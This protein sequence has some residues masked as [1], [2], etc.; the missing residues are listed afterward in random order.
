MTISICLDHTT[1]PAPRRQDRAAL[2]DAVE[3]RGPVNPDSLGAGSSSEAVSRRKVVVGSFI[4]GILLDLH[5]TATAPPTDTRQ[6]RQMPEPR[7]L[8]GDDTW[9]KVM[10]RK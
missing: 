7:L 2:D 5:S 6:C 10:P 8:R 9:S 3:Q 1:E 4:A